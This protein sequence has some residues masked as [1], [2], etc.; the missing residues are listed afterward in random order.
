MYAYVFQICA[1][2]RFLR[3][4]KNVIKW[5]QWC[6]VIF[7]KPRITIITRHENYIMFILRRFSC[8]RLF[9][10]QAANIETFIIFNFRSFLKSNH[11]LAVELSVRILQSGGLMSFP[12]NISHFIIPLKLMKQKKLLIR[13]HHHQ[14]TEFEQQ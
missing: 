14:F 9:S 11:F 2:M 7:E 3:F 6:L 4:N 5:I 13:F 10:L 8:P 12:A 1:Q